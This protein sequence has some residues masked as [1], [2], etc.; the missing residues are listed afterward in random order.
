ML[1][2]KT[3][4]YGIRAALYVAGQKEREF[5]PIREISDGLQISFHFLT[6]I[7]QILTNCGVLKS[8]R[9]P[10]GGVTLATPPEAVSIMQIILAIDGNALFK[11]CVLGLADCGDHQPCPMHHFWQEERSRI[12]DLFSSTS[13]A[14]ITKEIAAHNYRISGSI[15]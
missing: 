11:D 7:L 2:S 6:K 13:L 10:N 5:V 8:Y 12:S 3:C 4:D 14:D 1:L 9:G 15:G